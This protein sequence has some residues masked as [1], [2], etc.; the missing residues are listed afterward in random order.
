[1]KVYKR[2]SFDFSKEAVKRLNELT[3][4]IDSPSKAE[5]I[6]QALKRFEHIIH[7]ESKDYEHMIVKDGEKNCGACAFWLRKEREITPR[8][9]YCDKTDREDCLF[10]IETHTALNPEFVTREDFCCSHYEK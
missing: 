9:G 3:K 1:M 5:T 8:Y 6:R 4:E 10:T 2:I 7:M